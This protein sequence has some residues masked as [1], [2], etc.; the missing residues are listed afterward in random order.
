MSTPRSFVMLAVISIATIQAITSGADAANLSLVGSSMKVC[1][2]VGDT[3]WATGNPTAARTL[4]NFGLDAIDLGFPVDSGPP[5]PLYFLFGDALPP[6]HPPNSILSVPPDDAVGSTTRTNPPDSTACLDLQLLTSAPKTFAHPTVQPTIQQ[7]TFNVP[8]GGVFLNNSFYAFFWTDH[9]AFPSGLSP[10]PRTPLRRPPPSGACLENPES[11][12]VGRSV[13]AEATSA[14]PL[15]FNWT[16][17]AGR[18]AVPE[19]A[20]RL[21]LRE[22]GCAAAIAAV[23]R[24]SIRRG[25][26]P[27]QHSISS[28]GASRDIRRSADVVI[29]CRPGRGT[30]HL[31]HTPGVGKEPQR[32]RRMGTS[33]RRGLHRRAF[34]DMEAEAHE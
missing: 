19:Y 15:A 25:P 21:R 27:R 17:A 8:S 11:S 1:Q 2:L 10:E 26:L 5:G 13:L 23:R 14:N 33:T 24:S 6:G 22:R 30:S 31:A 3:D 29:F 32:S 20:K 18:L 12:S 9:C 34:R 4:S 28:N 16:P 7:G